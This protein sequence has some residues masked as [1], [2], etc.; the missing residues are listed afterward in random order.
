MLKSIPII[1][2]KIIAT[3]TV[4]LFAIS[5][6]LF[7]SP[8]KIY[9]EGL[10]TLIT[11]TGA[12]DTTTV[13]SGGTLQMSAA[14]LPV[15]ADNKIVVW[16]VS[17]GSGTASINEMTGLLTGENVGI[18]LVFATPTDDSGNSGALEITVTAPILVSS[19]SVTGAAGATTLENGGTLQM[20]AA[21]LPVDATNQGITWSVE[22]GT[23][24]ATINADGLLTGMGVG[25]VSIAAT[26]DDGSAIFETLEVTITTPTP[27]QVLVS[28]IIVSGADGATTLE[29]GSSLQMSA[30]VLPVDATDPNITW[31]VANGTGSA[32]IGSAGLLEGTGIGTV[33]ITA[34]ADDSSTI[35][36]T[37]LISVTAPAILVTSIIITG[38]AGETTVLNG[39]TLQMN[40]AVLPIDATDPN[41]TWSVTDGTGS[42]TINTSGVLTGTGVGAVT[43]SATADDGSAITETLEIS[44]IAPTPPPPQ[45]AA[46]IASD[47]SGGSEINTAEP[48]VSTAPPTPASSVVYEKTIIGFVTLFYNRILNRAPDTEGLNGWAAG[49]TS[50]ALADSALVRGFIF[51]NENKVLTAGD[52]NEQFITSLY[53][54][55]F[56]RT[57]DTGGLKSWL[58]NMS[59]GMTKEEVINY[60]T[61]SAEFISLYTEYGVKP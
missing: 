14:V 20:N 56:D 17:N 26:A 47:I 23:G 31:S 60:F 45:A 46:P 21:L 3:M 7:I 53:R 41:V 28:S 40:A 34:T 61:S 54:L 52:T 33:T 36:G 29:N 38:A 50:G 39:S 11:V 58:S 2:K 44:V 57:P 13:V 18:V 30:E 24:S 9:G 25:T 42:A 15:D 1:S 5:M 32:T 43:V 8:G 49:L 35:F 59:A 12:G 55:I 22:N 51:S 4:I 48:T 27:P 37:Y 6:A 16:S 10:V 19:I